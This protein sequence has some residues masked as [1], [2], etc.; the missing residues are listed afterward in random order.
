MEELDRY[1][2]FQNGCLKKPTPE[3]EKSIR[4]V[5]RIAAHRIQLKL[6]TWKLH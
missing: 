2:N 5:T 1:K 3:A 4:Q 6:R